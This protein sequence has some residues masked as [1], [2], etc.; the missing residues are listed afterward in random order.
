METTNNLKPDLEISVRSEIGPLNA[1]LLHRPGAEVENMT[2]RNVQRA[3]YSDILNLSVASEEYTQLSGA[4]GKICKVYEVIDLLVKVLDRPKAREELIQRICVTEGVTSYMEMLMGMKSPELA[5]VL[6]EGLPAR[7]DTLSSYLKNEYYALYP[8]YNFYF[9]RDAAVTLG[10][11]AL[12]CRMANKVR[13]RES[14]IMNAIYRY[15]GAFKCDVVDANDFQGQDSKVI[16][17]GGDIIV[18]R[19][20]ILIIGNGVR[21]T[22][23][24]IDFMIERFRRSAPA[25]RS[26]V[27]VQQLPYEPESFIHLDM[28]FTL[29]DKDKCMIFKPLIME[30]N[31]YQTVQITIDDGNV[32]S[33]KPVSGLL[34]AL[35]KLGMDLK[36]IICGGPD[37]WDQE[38]EQWHSGANFFSFAPGKV[39]TYARNVHT[40]EELS[41]GGFEIVKASDFIDGKCDST[42]FGDKPCAVTIAGAELARGGGGARCMTMPLSRKPV[43]W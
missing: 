7:I 14:L 42:V 15:S 13:M 36:P 38:R 25:G 33:I 39:L 22:P 18:A 43:Q 2:P 35:K 8:L 10:N 4:L 41:K 11:H 24:G 27:L 19:E 16:M 5:R 34:H 17:E 21:T 28:V 31:Q 32:T 20:D 26:Y 6:I 37:E 29:L 23:E 3:L 12:I 9:T 30:A 1:V 40:L